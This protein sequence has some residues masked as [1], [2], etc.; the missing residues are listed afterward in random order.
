M[1][2]YKPRNTKCTTKYFVSKIILNTVYVN[3][4]F[5][6]DFQRNASP[7]FIFQGTKHPG[8]CEEPVPYQVRDDNVAEP[9]EIL[10]ISIARSITSASIPVEFEVQQVNVMIIDNDSKWVCG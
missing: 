3:F 10:T 4:I 7:Y 5:S 6:A 9:D 1:I 2:I 8:C